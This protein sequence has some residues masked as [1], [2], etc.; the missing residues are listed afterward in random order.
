MSVQRR[1]RRLERALGVGSGEVCE[2][3]GVRLS[4]IEG[5]EWR[6]E[7][8]GEVPVVCERCGKPRPVVEVR[9]VESAEWRG[10]AVPR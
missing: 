2:C 9:F 7:A 3:G 8:E 5:A 10:M 6:G 4:F 1:L